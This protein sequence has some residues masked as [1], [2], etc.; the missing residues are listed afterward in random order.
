MANR[1]CIQPDC[2]TLTPVGRCP[3]HARNPNLARDRLDQVGTLNNWTCTLC[4]EPA[5]R[6]HRGTNHPHA[7]TIHHLADTS[8]TP[9][10]LT[11]AHSICNTQAR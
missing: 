2:P 7:P 10:N 3:L 8:D 1:P 9:P 11:L 4:G 5:P 6:H